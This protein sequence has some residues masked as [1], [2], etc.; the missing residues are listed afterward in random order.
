MDSSLQQSITSAVTSAVATSVAAIQTK[1]ENKMLSLREMI[2]KS[3]L[4]KESP[5][6]TPPL[7]L[8]ATPK[9]ILGSDSL[10]KT[11]TERWNQADLGYFNVHLNRAHGKDEIVLVG[12]DV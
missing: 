8:N 11:T 7:N 3:L 5:S 6:T 9:A 2:E 4:S 1:H 12:K 10:P